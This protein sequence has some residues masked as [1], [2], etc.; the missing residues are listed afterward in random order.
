MT[1]DATKP[2]NIFEAASRIEKERREKE[3][4]KQV[5]PP[6]A[7]PAQGTPLAAI[8]QRCQQL[9]NEIAAS[10][11]QAF[12]KGGITSTQLR[13]YV[14]RPQNFSQRDWQRIEEQKKKTDGMLQNLKRKIEIQQVEKMPRRIEEALETPPPQPKQEEELPPQPS[15]PEKSLPKP[16]MKK[17]RIMTRRQW[18]GM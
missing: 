4:Q 1:Q 8:F 10:L 14:S 6:A 12:K 9:H 2:H 7:E 18:I 13:T 17:P 15:L 16:Q 5:P 11:D 3:I